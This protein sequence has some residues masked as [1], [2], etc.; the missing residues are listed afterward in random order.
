M[1]RWG[2]LSSEVAVASARRFSTGLALMLKTEK[3]SKTSRGAVPRKGVLRAVLVADAASYSR[4]M[5]EDPMGT[6]TS[7][8]RSRARMREII[9]RHGGEDAGFP[10]DFLLAIFAAAGDALE[11]AMEFLKEAD[12]AGISVPLRFRVGLHVGDVF[13]Q[14]GEYL[15]VAI[16]IASRLQQCAPIGGIVMS[17]AFR[18]S[19]PGRLRLPVDDIGQLQLK[20]VEEPIHA[21]EV[22][23]SGLSPDGPAVPLRAGTGGTDEHKRPS[24][25]IEKRPR[26]FIRPFRAAGKAERALVF[27]D[28]LMEELVTTF[29]VFSDV[30]RVSSTSN[31]SE[32][33]DGYEITGQ[34]RNGDRLRITCHL[35]D[36]ST[37]D[38]IWSDRFDFGNDASYDAQERIVIA[39]TNALQLKLTDGE[40]AR[41]WSTQSTSMAAWEE[42]H[43][44]RMCEARYT[45]DGNLKAREHFGR[46][47]SLDPE[48]VPA[49]V[50]T[51]FSHLDAVRLGWASDHEDDLEKA[52]RLAES[53]RRMDPQDPYAIAL[54][55]YV[56]RAQGKLEQSVAT[57]ARAV[58]LAPR[59]GELVA[60]YADMLWMQGD[61]AGAVRQ[62]RRALELFPQPSSW[63]RGNLGLALLWTGDCPE[64][65]KVFET[66]IASDEDYARAYI[67]LVVA[68]VRQGR[69]EQARAAYQSLLLIE[70]GFVPRN[71]IARNLHFNPADA[72]RFMAD[73]M[74]AAR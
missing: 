53:A 11:S 62:N 38:A 66:V 45:S 52:F 34:V 35:T 47:M 50:A 24:R 27:A 32:R 46:A 73:L 71:W 59:N 31:S 57:M 9:R 48:F 41:L 49:V 55:A 67:G 58:H 63:V 25:R 5:P 44:G 6:I 13:E 28:G 39:V 64:A 61:A 74:L 23:G 33:R 65:Q 22:K 69:I 36:L 70:P 3:R 60:Y 51:G 56:E 4:L 68:L 7:L 17:Q 29:G 1:K 21:F 42:F 15:G 14:E 8:N 54:L 37:G 2:T 72:D 19:L 10:G 12:Q 30:F 26:I 18:Q 43:R 16:N 40:A 20:N